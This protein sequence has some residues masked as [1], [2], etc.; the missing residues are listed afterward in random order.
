MEVARRLSPDII[1]FGIDMNR[2]ER[3]AQSISL[4]NRAA[5]SVFIGEADAK[6][7]LDSAQQEAEAAFR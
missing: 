4:Y 3:L 7:A 6:T 1:I 5:Y 2:N